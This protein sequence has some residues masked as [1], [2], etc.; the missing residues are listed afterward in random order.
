MRAH[1]AVVLPSDSDGGVILHL[2]HKGPRKGPLFSP[3][4]FFWIGLYRAHL[5][6]TQR[7][8]REGLARRT[9]LICNL[10]LVCLKRIEALENRDQSQKRDDTF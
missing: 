5:S 10:A 3:A 7:D 1:A 8:H 9:Y 2:M 6:D 4:L